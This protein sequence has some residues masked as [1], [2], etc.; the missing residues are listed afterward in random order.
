LL[1][2]GTAGKPSTDRK[3]ARWQTYMDTFA[4]EYAHIPGDNNLL[5]DTLSRVWEGY[6]TDELAEIKQNGDDWKWN[7]ARDK[8]ENASDQPDFQP[9]KPMSRET[10]VSENS[11][12]T[13]TTPLMPSIFEELRGN[14]YVNGETLDV[15]FGPGCQEALAKSQEGDKLYAGAFKKPADFKNF[16]ASK[17]D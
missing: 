17:G 11:E 14:A 6:T 16:L 12:T 1:G 4:M 5:A 15:V 8:P 10:Q 13:E 3:L 9:N 7:M 2:Q